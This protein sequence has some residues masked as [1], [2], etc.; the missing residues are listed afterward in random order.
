MN[1]MLLGL[2]AASNLHMFSEEYARFVV[3]SAMLFAIFDLFR[4]AKTW[5]IG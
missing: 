3:L 5:N 4:Y 1:T 2:L